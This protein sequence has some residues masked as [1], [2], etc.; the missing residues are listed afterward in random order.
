MVSLPE[1]KNK[2]Y[3]FVRQR[4]KCADGRQAKCRQHSYNYLERQLIQLG[5][6]C[7]RLFANPHVWFCRCVLEALHL[8]AFWTF[9]FSLGFVWT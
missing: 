2:R 5:F 1:R 3:S 9:V 8:V 4:T 7:A 6:T